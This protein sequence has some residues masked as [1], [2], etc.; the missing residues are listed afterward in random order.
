[1]LVLSL[2]AC[3]RE[4]ETVMVVVAAR[5]LSVGVP[6]TADD[7]Y[8][9]PM[10]PQYLPEGGVFD[11]PEDVIGRVPYERIL[12]NE[13][14]RAGRLADAALQK[15]L[16]ALVPR[17]HHVVVFGLADDAV[18]APVAGVDRVEVRAGGQ[19]VVSGL[20]VLRTDRNQIAAIVSAE[21]LRA[22]DA[23]RPNQVLVVDV[24]R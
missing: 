15:Q 6:I 1:M 12:A 11:H 14:I 7:V 24:A 19:V 4:P 22:I 17:D 16:E 13:P 8:G 18:R 10:E 3:V 2:L 5:D 20:D 9:Y 23:A 21:Q